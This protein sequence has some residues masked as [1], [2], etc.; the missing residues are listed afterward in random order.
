MFNSLS[1]PVKSLAAL[2]WV[3]GSVILFVKSSSLLM[4][5]DNLDPDKP[6]L[7]IAILTGLV[8]GSIKTKY[9]FNR[10]CNKNLNR[11]DD[12]EKPRLWHC[13][14]PQF[15]I[16][17]FLMVALGAYMSKVAQGSY[18]LLI[19]VATVDLSI[20]TALLGSSLCFWKTRQI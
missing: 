19:S 12:L 6:W 17:L 4:E 14:R 11:I 20:A 18:Y 2:I 15:F 1:N 5:A 16:F 7:W 8:I 13:Y 3:S 9:L 10:L